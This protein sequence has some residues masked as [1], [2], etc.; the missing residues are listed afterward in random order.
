MENWKMAFNIN[1]LNYNDLLMVDGIGEVTAGKIV[2]RRNQKRITWEMMPSVF[3]KNSDFKKAL[4][5]GLIAD[6]DLR[7]WTV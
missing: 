4:D 6:D 2:E 1:N 5:D 3:S 7:I